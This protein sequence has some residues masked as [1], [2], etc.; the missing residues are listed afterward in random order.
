MVFKSKIRAF[1]VLFF[2]SQALKV[3]SLEMSH[4]V[5]SSNL[6][7]LSLNLHTSLP[8]EISSLPETLLSTNP[9]FISLQEVDDEDALF[10]L[11]DR[12][13]ERYPYFIVFKGLFI[14]SKYPIEHPLFTPVYRGEEESGVL[15]DCGIIKDEKILCRLYALHVP[16]EEKGV[17]LKGILQKMENDCV[18]LGDETI[19]Y[20]LCGDLTGYSPFLLNS[21]SSYPL[22]IVSQRCSIKTCPFSMNFSQDLIGQLVAVEQ[23][24]RADYQIVLCET[25]INGSVGGDK[26][27]QGNSQVDAKVGVTWESDDGNTRVSG[28]VEGSVKDNHGHRESSGSVSVECEYV[29]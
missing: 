11:Y 2:L 16:L 23:H 29:F 26:D 21:L 6:T 27:E 1:G 15:F 17:E 12:L 25:T 20:L 10:Y 28:G 7:I 5:P 13:N 9:D 19:P 8:Q 22:Q 24:Q 14:A 4:N 3:F 18:A